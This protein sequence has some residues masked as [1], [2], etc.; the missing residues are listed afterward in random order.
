MYQLE[1]LA[2]QLHVK[3]LDQLQEPR[4]SITK[5]LDA[6]QT[7]SARQTE[8]SLARANLIARGQLARF[9]VKTGDNR[10]LTVIDRLANPRENS[11]AESTGNTAGQSI[12][13]TNTL[14]QRKADYMKQY[15]RRGLLSLIV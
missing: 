3:I 13:L 2:S 5:S 12:R 6:R 10:Q 8:S 7:L 11:N 9:A 4:K 1:V 14:I 15:F